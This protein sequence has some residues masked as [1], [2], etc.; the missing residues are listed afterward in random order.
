M[1]KYSFR[2]QNQRDFNAR[3]KR[4]DPGFA[5]A[6]FLS[7]GKDMTTAR[8]VLWT[9]TGFAW[10][11][12]VISISNNKSSIRESLLQ[13]SLPQQHHDLVLAALSGLLAVS[14]VMFLLHVVRFVMKQGPKRSNSCGILTGAL[15]AAA[16]VYTPPSV[17]SAGFGMLDQNSQSL[18]M[19]AHSTVKSSVPGVDWDKIALVS[20]LGK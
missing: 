1:K 11:Y 17:L 16:L 6:A 13:G 3:V 7:N 8:P 12:L 18:L 10:F 15:A 19:A 20:S 4:L 5:G 9:L 2:K 14:G